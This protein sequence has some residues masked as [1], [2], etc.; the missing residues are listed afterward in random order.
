MLFRHESLVHAVRNY[1]VCYLGGRYGGGKTAFSFRLA[2]E[3][4][5]NRAF[6]FRYLLSNVGSV[7]ATAPERVVLRDGVWADAVMILDE[8]GMFLDSPR[9]AKQWLAYLRKLNIVLIIPSVIEPALIMRRCT[10]Q[11]LGN[12]QPYGVPLWHFGWRLDSHMLKQKSS[13]F[14]WGFQ[15]IFGI[16]DTL[17]MPADADKHLE[18]IEKWV[19]QAS[20]TLGYNASLAGRKTFAPL[21]LPALPAF[22]SVDEDLIE[23]Q[24]EA[25]L[26]M[27]EQLDDLAEKLKQA[28]RRR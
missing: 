19:K 2:Y 12:F 21:A 27:G 24:T 18:F 3:L 20:T 6:G 7:W 16:Y 5:T 25:S 10:V 9:E 13:F 28:S 8:G 11:R 17:G 4:M 23:A 15:E 26:Y 22:S 14:W 1:R